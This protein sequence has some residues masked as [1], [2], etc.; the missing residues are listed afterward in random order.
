MKKVKCKLIYEANMWMAD[1]EYEDIKEQADLGKLEREIKGNLDDILLEDK[2][3]KSSKI[4]TFYFGVDKEW[5]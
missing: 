5:Q 1:R 3:N 4:K 2:S